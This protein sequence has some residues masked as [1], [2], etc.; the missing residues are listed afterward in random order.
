MNNSNTFA[1]L[2]GAAAG[3]AIGYWLNTD[4][5]KQFR[6]DLSANLENTAADAKEKLTEKLDASKETMDDLAAK[7][8]DKISDLKSMANN[9]VE[10]I[11]S[12]FEK[13][14]SAAQREIESFDQA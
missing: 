8:K 12:K 14:A 1:L 2:F 11:E 6:K 4:S 5:G 9:Q 7:A 3:V 13:G 10:N